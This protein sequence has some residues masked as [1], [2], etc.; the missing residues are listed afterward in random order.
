MQLKKKS[1]AKTSK[2]LADYVDDLSLYYAASNWNDWKDD[3]ESGMLEQIPVLASDERFKR[4]CTEYKVHR[5]IKKNTGQKFRK[6]LQSAIREIVSD[7]SGKRIDSFEKNN[8]R[9]FSSLG[10]HARMISVI[11]KVAAFA[12]P[13]TFLAWDRYARDGVK[14]GVRQATSCDFLTYSEYLGKA[15]DLWEESGKGLIV[16]RLR[17]TKFNPPSKSNV[18]FLRRVFDV[19]LMRLGGRSYKPIEWQVKFFGV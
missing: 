11:S 9:L 17:Y 2:I 16:E 13:E 12:R 10:A 6:E 1:E 8:R 3:Y 4:F 7:E 18:A 15:N 19:A 5:T 14:I